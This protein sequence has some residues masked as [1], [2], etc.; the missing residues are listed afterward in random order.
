MITVVTRSSPPCASCVALKN[1]LRLA[2][3]VFE[4]VDLTVVGREVLTDIGI[5]TVPAVFTGAISRDTYVGNG[6]HL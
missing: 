2:S 5:R 1:K 3:I 6:D 4:E